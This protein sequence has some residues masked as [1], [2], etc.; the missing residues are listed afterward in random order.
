MGKSWLTSRMDI[1]LY[2]LITLVVLRLHSGQGS[3]RMSIIWN[4]GRS[5]ERT[6]EGLWCVIAHFMY[7]FFTLEQP[8]GSVPIY[9]MSIA[10]VKTDS[11]VCKLLKCG[12]REVILKL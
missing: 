1:I 5:K 10:P 2:V 9:Y 7:T 12:P 11:L 3:C 6:R 8:T 4:L